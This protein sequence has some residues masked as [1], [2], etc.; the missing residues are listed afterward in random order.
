LQTIN[1]YYFNSMTRL[2]GTMLIYGHV[3]RDMLHFSMLRKPN[4]ETIT[5]TLKHIST[6]CNWLPDPVTVND[7]GTLKRSLGWC[8]AYLNTNSHRLMWICGN[9]NENKN[10]CLSL[11]HSLLLYKLTILSLLN[12]PDITSISWRSYCCHQDK[13]G[14]LCCHLSADRP[15]SN[16]SP[17]TLHNSNSTVKDKI[18]VCIHS[19]LS[20]MRYY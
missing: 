2:L 20:W 8:I 7:E 13:D 4:K 9:N 10:Y 18:N 14:C 3:F 17:K 19:G 12:Q 6:M 11:S 5:H 15:P 1:L 16:S